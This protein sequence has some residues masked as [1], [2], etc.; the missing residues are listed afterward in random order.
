MSIPLSYSLF[1]FSLVTM[2]IFFLLQHLGTSGPLTGRISRRPDDCGGPQ[3]TSHG[4]PCPMLRVFSVSNLLLDLL[5]Q[6]SFVL[7]PLAP[8]A[9]SKSQPITYLTE[10]TL[11]RSLNQDQPR[12]TPLPRSS[13]PR[14]PR[15][16]PVHNYTDISTL[17]LVM[18]HG[19]VCSFR[20]G[21]INLWDL[22]R[23]TKGSSKRST[24]LL[25]GQ[26]R[27]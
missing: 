11:T 7:S 8:T 21:L 4:F 6:C 9:A 19:V 17:T 23:G 3:R 10:L 12:E 13:G 18:I 26:A 5:A 27:R 20:W 2:Y 25:R 1:T 24:V 15:S 22:E 16:L 14:K